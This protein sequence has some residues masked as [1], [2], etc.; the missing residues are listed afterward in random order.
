MR[1]LPL[2]GVEIAL[3]SLEGF[4]YVL[5]GVAEGDRAAVGA[6][7]GVLGPAEC[8]EEP[9]DLVRSQGLIDLDGG[10]AGDAGCDAAAA[11]LGV[12]RLLIAVGN[13]QDLFDHP[14]KLMAFETYGSGFDGQGAGAKGFSFK[15]VALQLFGYLGEGDHLGG[16]EIDEQRHEEALA[17][18]L[19]GI[20]VA[21]DFFEEDALVG[22]VLVD[23]PEALLVG[24]EDEG[25]AELAEGLE[26]GEGGEG[27]GLLGGDG[28]AVEARRGAVVAYG[29]GVA[30]EGEAAGGGWDD[31]GGEIEEG[32]LCRG[33]MEGFSVGG[34]VVLG[35]GKG[36]CSTWPKEWFASCTCGW[37]GKMQG[38]FAGL[39]MTSMV[40]CTG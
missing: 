39:R 29:D 14:F 22:Y 33:D 2:V 16:K 20:A 11:S 25:V 34:R 19:F 12:L 35:L 37:I 31:G 6:G 27:V 23:D 36:G 15:A 24:G 30:G 4:G 1:S 10:V 5:V 26:G 32:G 9:F 17:L 8:G 40:V 13:G 7:G 38:S 18:D 28:L 3:D 21:E